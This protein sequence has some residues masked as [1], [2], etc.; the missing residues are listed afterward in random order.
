MVSRANLFDGFCRW[1][2]LRQYL[3]N[4]L[5]RQVL[6]YSIHIVGGIKQALY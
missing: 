4:F 1:L 5:C 2:C 3:I 6:K